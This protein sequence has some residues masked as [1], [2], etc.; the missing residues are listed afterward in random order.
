MADNIVFEATNTVNCFTGGL[1]K[2]LNNQTPVRVTESEILLYGTGFQFRSGYDEYGFPELIFDVIETSRTSMERFGSELKKIYVK[3]D[4]S[5]FEQ[6][7]EYLEAY[8][9]VLVWVN[10]SFMEYSEVYF[11]RDSY[12]HS[13]LLTGYDPDTENFQLFDSLIVDRGR[14]CCDAT[15]SKQKLHQGLVTPIAGNELAPEI[16]TIFVVDASKVSGVSED[17]IR[18]EL[19]RQAKANI[20]N[21]IYKDSIENYKNLCMKFFTDKNSNRRRAARR[22]FDHISVLFVVPSLFHLRSDLI[23]AQYPEQAIGDLD[24]IEKLWRELSI[25]ALKFETTELDILLPRIETKFDA[26]I[27]RSSTFWKKISTAYNG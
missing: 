13:I 27:E 5:W 26:I 18:A 2:A 25:L 22:L 16:G 1:I 23:R 10:S 7:L 6:I 4:D 24:T 14:V 9:S 3:G 21:D 8:G 15:I 11:K 17:S 19:L 20:E 12:L